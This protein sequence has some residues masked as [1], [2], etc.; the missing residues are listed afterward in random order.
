MTTPAIAAAIVLA[1]ISAA[2]AHSRYP[3]NCCHDNDCKPMPCNELIQTR[4]GL[5]WRG[6]VYFADHMVKPSQD[7]FCYVCVKEQVD[8]MPYVPLCVFVPPTS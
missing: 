6:L 8:M 3:H 7:Q 2:E 5:T 4:D 1:S